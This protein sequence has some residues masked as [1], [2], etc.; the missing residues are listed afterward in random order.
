M[1]LLLVEDNRS[2]AD[3]I[4]GGLKRA[5]FAVD[6]FATAADAEEALRAV[7]YDLLILDLGLPDRDGTQLLQNLRKQGINAPVIIVTARGSVDDRVAGLNIG[8]DDYLVKPF[9]MDELIARC[10]A[11][12]RRP[13]GRSSVAL[14]AGNVSVDT[15]TGEVRINDEVIDI[16]RR[17]YDILV[18][19]LRQSGRVVPKARFE[20]ALYGFG[21]EVTPNAIE[22]HVSRLR[23]R[24]TAAAATPAIHTIRG[25]GYLLKA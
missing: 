8:A 11:L 4:A 6:H 18:L 5:G 19:L 16:G 13:G 10:R 24:L 9:E 7:T 2:L 23:K 3:L 22:A 21:E 14:A 15:V 25:I 12:L 1:R 20:E 17:E